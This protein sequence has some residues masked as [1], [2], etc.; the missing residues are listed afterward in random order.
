MNTNTVSDHL[1][2]KGYEEPQTYGYTPSNPYSAYNEGSGDVY[3]PKIDSG[4]Y[5]ISE[6]DQ[7]ALQSGRLNSQPASQSAQICPQCKG[8][9]LEKDKVYFYCK[10]NHKWKIN[11]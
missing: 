5:A 1:K 11:N 2:S 3:I 4:V 9:A 7:A 8:D 6:E 10:K